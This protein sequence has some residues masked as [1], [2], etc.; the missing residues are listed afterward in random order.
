MSEEVKILCLE[1]SSSKCSVAMIFGNKQLSSQSEI[2]QNHAEVIMSM[3]EGICKQSGVELAQLD[4][5]AISDGPGSYTGLRIGTSTAKGICYALNI[6]LIAISTLKALAYASLKV[7]DSELLWPM[8]DARR[9]E[10]YQGIYNR[11]LE[12]ISPISSTILTDLD[13]KPILI[14]DKTVSLCG[15]GAVKA[16]EILGY[17]DL[18]IL[19]EAQHLCQLAIEGYK[20]R[21]FVDLERYEPFYLKS[22]NITVAVK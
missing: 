16:S 14:E 7:C 5:I 11:H 1:T 17:E 20:A 8:I 13:F 21:D 18:H 10:V 2:I 12:L 22:A 3:I 9:M 4:A 19:P 6:P 15:D